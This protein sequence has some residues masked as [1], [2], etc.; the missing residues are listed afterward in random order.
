VLSFAGSA[1]ASTLSVSEHFAFVDGG[2][3]EYHDLNYDATPGERNN[4]TVRMSPDWSEVAF[5]EQKI[6][7]FIA[8]NSRLQT[9]SFEAQW[10]CMSLHTNDAACVAQQKAPQSECEVLGNCLDESGEPPWFK[11]VTVN[12]SDGV[13]RVDT[14]DGQPTTVICA[15]G[16]DTVIADAGDTVTGDC[17]S[18]TRAS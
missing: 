17:L 18:V 12:L 14:A 15:N 11:W 16:D 9:P 4:L 3:I 6:D 2:G 8:F 7:I 5:R 1:S 10:G 13:D